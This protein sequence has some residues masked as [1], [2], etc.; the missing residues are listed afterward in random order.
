MPSEVEEREGEDVNIEDDGPEAEVQDNKIAQDHFLPSAAEVENHRVNHTPYRSWCE[1]CVKG[2]SRKKTHQNNKTKMGGQDKEEEEDPVPR[3]SMD[4]FYMSQEDGE[5]K[6]NPCLVMVNDATDEKYARAV[7]QKGVQYALRGRW[8]GWS[9]TSPKN[10]KCGDTKGAKE[11]I[12][13]LRT[14]RRAAS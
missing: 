5:A 14:T 10:S 2:R 8:I 12:S 6:S 13:P 11:E 9:N 1:Y 3:V 7:G 4:Y